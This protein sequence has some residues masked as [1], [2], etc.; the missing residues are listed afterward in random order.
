MS[1]LSEKPNAF[2]ENL[3]GDVAGRVHDSITE[4]PASPVNEERFLTNLTVLRRISDRICN[5]KSK[6]QPAQQVS[7]LR[8][9]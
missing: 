6:H 7:D 2:K 8:S 5:V 9:S 3:H 1:V 4:V